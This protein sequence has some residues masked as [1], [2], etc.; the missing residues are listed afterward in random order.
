MNIASSELKTVASSKLQEEIDRELSS[1]DKSIAEVL[2]K[3]NEEESSRTI[4][5]GYNKDSGT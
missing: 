1:K 2:E 3:D 4:N 5:S